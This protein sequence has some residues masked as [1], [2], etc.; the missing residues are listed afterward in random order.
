MPMPMKLTTATLR[1]LRVLCGSDRTAAFALFLAGATTVA[2]QNTTG[3][4]AGFVRDA[5]GGAMPGVVVTLAFPEI[6][7]T[8]ETVSNAGGYFVFPGVPNG[9]ATLR[10]EVQGFRPA[11]RKDLVVELN[12][13]MRVDLTLHVAG[14][15]ETVEVVAAATPAISTRADIAHLITGEQT[16]EIP[17]DGRSYMQLVN[18]IPGVSR[19]DGSYEFGTSFRA[20]G[21]QINGL[22][23]NFSALTLDG[24]ENLDAGSNATQ[25]NNVSID[26]IEEFKV[27]SSQY[28]AE[29]GKAGG[30]QINVVTKSGKRDFAGGA[31][32]FV[33]NGRF[34][35]TDPLTGQ[36]TALDFKNP[37]WTLGGPIAWRGFNEGRSK[38][39]FFGAQEW[40]RLD[41]QVGLT[42][43]V[44]VPSALERRGDF[45]QSARR[46]TDPLT[47]QPFPGGVIP[48]DRLSPAG[49]A[50][51]ARFPEPDGGA[52]VRAT[53]APTQSR[54]I[55]EDI[56][57]LDYRPRPAATA[58]FRYIRDR[59]DQLEPYGSFGGTSN[60]AQVPTSHKRYSDSY[61]ISV[62]HGVGAATFH[63]LSVSAVRND[64]ELN[65]SGDLYQRTGISIPE[66]FP[67]NRNTRAPN[68]RSMTGYTLGTGL[69]GNDYPTHLIGNYYTIKDNVTFARGTHT[70]KTGAYVG[71]FRKAEELRTSDAGAFSFTDTQTGGTGI[72]L[73]NLLIGRYDQYT[74]SDIAPYPSM[75]YYQ[76]E[77]YGQDHWQLRSNLTIDYGIRYQ[78]MPAM[79]ERADQIATFDPARY[80][81]ADAPQL[82]STGNLV[83]GTGLLINGMPAT[84]LAIAGQNGVPRGLYDAD[85]NDWAPRVGFTWDPWRRA[86]TLIRGGVGVFYDRPVTNSTRDQASSP[87]FVRTVVLSS[88][89]VD[90]PAGGAASTAPSG[91]FEAIAT[92]FQAPVVYQW[93][94]GVQ[95]TLPWQLVADVNY[96]GNEA[97]HLLRVREMNFATPDPATGRAPTPVNAYRPYVGYSRITINETTAR[98][99][100]RALQLSVNR[101]ST[102]NLSLGLAYTLARSRGDADSEDSTSSGSLPQ[103]PRNPAAEYASQDFDRRHVLAVNYVW[104]LPWLR[105]SRTAIGRVAGGWQV[106]GVTRFNTGRRLN[107]TAGTNSAIFGDTVTIRANGVAGVDPNS[108]PAGGRTDTLWLNPAAFARPAA[109][110]L[111]DLPR[112]AVVGPAYFSSD[113]SVMKNVRL[114]GPWKIQLRAEAFNVFNRKN[115]RTIS[116]NITAADFGAVTDY[117]PQRIF[118]F[119]AKVIF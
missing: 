93:S 12:A 43:S 73:A 92:D 118:Q 82:T 75:R 114:R 52:G 110:T 115:L 88:G 111:G 102:Q 57:R 94:L 85:T 30:A 99:D 18:V 83:P 45:S 38:L 77:A 66:L 21:Q 117:E 62:T 89:S 63:E 76:I 100:Y 24:S 74:E 97:R 78:Y 72:A 17:I 49:V 19:N 37:G 11:E 16:R 27:L 91:G 47:G 23:K 65:Q 32:A 58:T 39:F 84:G 116:T 96:V 53:L 90:N 64:Q 3:E 35:A 54:D 113:L 31:Y 34:D 86:A 7:Y 56:L 104:Y 119:G 103:D 95:R 5:S 67:L 98:S 109:N 108:E 9:T 106:S 81:R 80:N 68:V 79:T 40:K 22:R 14:V 25:V 101:R 20:D 26:A 87:P 36:R 33:R 4:V 48:A 46:P 105:D 6:A 15:V 50:L 107:I 70:F 51:A 29:Y 41:T 28:A 71:Q 42:K 8:R 61:M 55:S 60:Y 59:V 44:T 1:G 2:A 112:N 69:L 10:A 13:R